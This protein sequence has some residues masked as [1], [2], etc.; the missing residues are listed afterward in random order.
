MGVLVGHRCANVGLN[1]GETVGQAQRQNGSSDLRS[2]PALGVGTALEW[3][4]A[5]GAAIQFGSPRSPPSAT[6][7]CSS[8][9]KAL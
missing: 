2:W 3:I 9:D 7:A 8:G 6:K 5:I 4:P 1:I